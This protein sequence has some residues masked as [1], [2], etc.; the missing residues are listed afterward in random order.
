MLHSREELRVEN[1]EWLPSQFNVQNVLNSH[2]SIL[3]VPTF[4]WVT[5]TAIS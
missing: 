5:A 3:V 4:P 1:G 2:F